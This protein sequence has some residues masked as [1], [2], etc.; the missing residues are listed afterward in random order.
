[1]Y[2]ANQAA[3]HECASRVCHVQKYCICIILSYVTAVSQK[4]AI[5]MHVK[6]LPLPLQILGPIEANELL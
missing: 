2:I 5:S 4:H 1:M 6:H 3:L